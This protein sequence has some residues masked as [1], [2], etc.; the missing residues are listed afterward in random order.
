MAKP[1]TCPDCSGLGVLFLVELSGSRRQV[2]CGHA[3]CMQA[4]EDRLFERVIKHTEMRDSAR[5]LGYANTEDL[6]R[7]VVAEVL[8]HLPRA[9][10]ARTPDQ[11][12]R[13]G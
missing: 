7:R 9:N 12:P 11:G 6:V 5:A 10:H 3:V 2:A 13:G 4:R 1:V 8:R